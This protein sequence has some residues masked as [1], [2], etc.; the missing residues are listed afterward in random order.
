VSIL[1]KLFGRRA[2]I[3]ADA[4]MSPQQATEIIQRY[5]A[6]LEHAAPAPGCVADVSKLPFPKSQ[7]KKALLIGL[8]STAD[9]SPPS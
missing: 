2:S 8:R 3:S 7:I 5:G 4:D 6:V 1:G 9:P